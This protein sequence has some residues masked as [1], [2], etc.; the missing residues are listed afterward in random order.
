MAALE[1][2]M[3]PLGTHAPDFKL[4]DVI[5]GKVKSLGELKST[6]ATVVMFICNHCPYVKNIRQELV[7]V[8]KAYIAKGVSFVAISSNDAN[9]YPEDAPERLKEVA[10]QL[11]YP[12]SLLYDESQDVAH[13]YDAVCTPDF[14]IFDGSLRLVYRG[15]FDDSRPSNNA[16]VNGKDLRNALDAILAGKAVNPKQKPSI[17]CSIKWK[18]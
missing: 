12:F 5:S 1:S 17:G 3:V 6:I 13:E 2:S 11:G 7:K 15:Q 16:P 8:A 9:E 18:E 14:F 10:I 4:P